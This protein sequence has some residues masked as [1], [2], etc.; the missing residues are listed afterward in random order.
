M[1]GE[2]PPVERL[3]AAAPY[4]DWLRALDRVAGDEARVV[5]ERD[6]TPVAALLSI[7]DL[8][9]FLWMDAARREEF[10]PLHELQRAY[11]EAFAG[12]PEEE[13]EAEIAKAIAEVRAEN[14]EALRRTASA[15]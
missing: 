9:A 10:A 15:S 13:I 3:N 7:G 1:Y 5:I 14:R 11:A 8:R 12:V 2:L 6:G 4:P